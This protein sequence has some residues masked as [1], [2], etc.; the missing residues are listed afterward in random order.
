[1]TKAKAYRDRIRTLQRQRK[2]LG[3]IINDLL[4]GYGPDEISDQPL[5]KEA[6]NTLVRMKLR[7]EC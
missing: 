2:R 3:E 7:K 6:E 4:L 5:L 1:M